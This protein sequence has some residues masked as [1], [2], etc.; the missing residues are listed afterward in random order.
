[1]YRS[2]RYGVEAPRPRGDPTAPP[3][4]AK[5]PEG[6]GPA[7][8]GNPDAT[9]DEARETLP[10][11]IAAFV[12]HRSRG[13]WY[14][15]ADSSAGGRVP[16]RFVSVD[17][18]SIRRSGISRYAATVRF[19]DEGGRGLDAEAHASLAGDAWT[20]VELERRGAVDPGDARRCF[21]KAVKKR[22]AAGAK[23]GV[24]QLEDADL[25]RPWKLKLRRIREET[26]A[27][28]GASGWYACVDFLDKEG[29]RSLDVD[30]YASRTGNRCAV[31]QVVIHRVDGKARTIKPKPAGAQ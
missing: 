23:R 14:A 6:A 8:E 7:K 28:Y 12:A 25:G 11:L 16:A 27:S 9:L 29:G 18:A 20:V 21:E 17:A 24:F 31:D 30:F 13:G 10:S 19:L 3:S 1:V 22:V 2:R 26:L 5:P 4:S 15:L